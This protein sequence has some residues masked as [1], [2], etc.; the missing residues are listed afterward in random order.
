MPHNE[1][2]W[3]P[4]YCPNCGIKFILTDNQEYLPKIIENKADDDTNELLES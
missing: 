1:E 2:G 3:M 4:S